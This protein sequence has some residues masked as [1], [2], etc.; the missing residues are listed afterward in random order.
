MSPA[1]A[2]TAARDPEAVGVRREGR[3]LRDAGRA[4]LEQDVVGVR[5]R[6]RDEVVDVLEGVVEEAVGVVVGAEHPREQ[7][8]DA[9]P[10]VRS[11]TSAPVSGVPT[12]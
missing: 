6:D 11:R 1:A 2:A 7:L 5:V 4:H 9:R 8:H 3:A 10:E 12:A